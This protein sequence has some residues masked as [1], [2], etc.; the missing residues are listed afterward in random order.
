VPDLCELAARRDPALKRLAEAGA[1][2]II[3]C[4]PRSIRW[5]FAAAGA[6]LPEKGVRILDLRA[7]G[8]AKIVR[9][10][11]LKASAAGREGRRAKAGAKAAS[12][13]HARKDAAGRQVPRAKAQKASAEALRADLDA[14]AKPLGQWVPWFPVI[15]RSRC[16]NCK[17]CLDFCLFGTYALSA[18]GKVRVEH[19]DHC[20]TNCPACAR[21]CPQMAIIFPKHPEGPIDGAEVRK[22]DLKRDD[23]RI[24]LAVHSRGDIFAVLRARSQAH[25][26]GDPDK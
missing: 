7:D 10:L 12:K 26:A 4:H 9:R 23:V 8:A 1:L 21:V 19:P 2:C 25:D 11:A 18:D 14:A 20:K 16:K 22:E 3:A 24:G 5:L 6:P 15:D 13:A 17:Q